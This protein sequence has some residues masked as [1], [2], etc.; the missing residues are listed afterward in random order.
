MNYNDLQLQ[1]LGLWYQRVNKR[2]KE[3]TTIK[4]IMPLKILMQEK[5]KP[6]VPTVN[7][8]IR[9]SNVSRR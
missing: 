6:A 5:R 4:K 3:L 8:N 2:V 9:K 7:T 1:L